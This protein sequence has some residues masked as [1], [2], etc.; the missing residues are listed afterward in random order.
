[1]NAPPRPGFHD[2]G[3]Y[4]RTHDLFQYPLPD[5]LRDGTRVRIAAFDH[6]FCTVKDKDGN[7]WKKVFMA[8]LRFLG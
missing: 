4:A 6:G 1:M 7:V 8:A 2:V 5:G 3:A